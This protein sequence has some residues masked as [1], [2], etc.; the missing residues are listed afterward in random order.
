MK[1]ELLRIARPD[2]FNMIKDQELYY[3]IG[4]TS[5]QK[6]DFV[7]PR[8]GNIVNQMVGNAARQGLS[9]KQCGDGISFGEKFVFNVLEQLQ[10]DFDIHVQFAWSNGKIYDACIYDNNGLCA[11]LIEIHG[12]QHYGDGF[13]SCGG[14]SYQQEVINDAYKMQLAAENGFVNN[15]YVVIDCRV[16]SATH[17]KNSIENHSYFHQYDLNTID[18]KQC[19]QNATSSY[20]MRAQDLWNDGYGVGAIAKQLKIAR[21]TV[22]RY[23]KQGAEFG[24]CSYSAKESSRRGV[25]AI[26]LAKHNRV[27]SSEIKINSVVASPQIK[28]I[29]ASVNQA[30]MVTG[31]CRTSIYDCLSGKQR[32]AGLTQ[33]GVEMTWCKISQEQFDNMLNNDDFIFVDV[34][35]N[36]NTK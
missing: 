36:N 29:F 30:S 34:Q 35:L 22:R 7:C 18:W 21:Y 16:S 14:R 15:S 19:L 17:I 23:L 33:D 1:K 9:C 32:Y 31:I 5:K 24:L 2:V 6:V 8:C 10:L 11:T 27:Y 4:K 13:E 25:D 26:R 12:Q 28:T 20:V 3:N